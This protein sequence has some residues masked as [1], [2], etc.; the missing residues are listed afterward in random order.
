MEKDRKGRLENGAG[1]GPA[2]TRSIAI[3]KRWRSL[4]FAA[5]CAGGVLLGAA[6]AS[7][8]CTQ[9]TELR[10]L[11]ASVDAHLKCAELGTLGHACHAPRSPP[12]CGTGLP[13]AVVEAV[14]GPT[15]GPGTW[16]SS[17]LGC[18]REIRRAASRYVS[19]RLKERWRLRRP[20]SAGNQFI[21]AAARCQGLVV[22]VDPVAGPMPRLGPVCAFGDPE[23]S[24]RLEQAL[25]C[26]RADLEQAIDTVAPEALR[27]NI[28]IIMT[29]DQRSD[30]LDLMPET[31]TRLAARGT[32]FEN[33]FA[34]SPVCAPSRATLMSGRLPHHQPSG[35]TLGF[36][37]NDTLAVWLAAQGYATGMF[38]KYT[39]ST[40]KIGPVVP[41][42]W[43]SWNVFL[44]GAGGGF[45]GFE[46]SFQGL[47]MPFP[48]SIYSTD[49]LAKQAVSFVRQH[50]QEPFFLMLSAFAPHSPAI[51]A[52]RH[53]GSLAGLEDWRPASWKEADL[54]GKP[55]WVS[56]WRHLIGPAGWVAVDARRRAEFETLLAVDEAVARIDDTLEAAGLTDQT[57]VLYLSDHGI[58]WGEH[59]LP[60]KWS[61]Y[62][63]SIR[64]PLLM[65]WPML[66]PAGGGVRPELVAMPDVT[67]TLAVVAG[68]V[69]HAPDGADLIDFLRQGGP[70][71]EDVLVQSP[72]EF[73]TRPNRAVRT[74][75]WKWI[76]TDATAGVREE[77]YDLVNDPLELTNL[78]SDPA[79]VSER[80]ALRAR[81]AELLGS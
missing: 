38:G 68:A 13:E 70:W 45:Y 30:A 42:G 77:L 27:P 55:D 16:S 11:G 65:R 24:G 4:G 73:I 21:A 53:A 66:D 76:E 34:T 58:H 9:P 1:K 47:F 57:L 75:R 33:S 2:G 37:Q 22:E 74:E 72:G 43:D 28:V 32:R 20:T 49:F 25:R 31:L 6:P 80:E 10:L 26:L 52:E 44:G 51:P 48:A 18:Q 64:I 56:G 39:N 41:P 60:T 67:A 12:A 7:A 40:E 8:R 23:M 59:W 17:A 19:D 50:R 54:S 29:D 5:A 3:R 46:M 81:L 63:E 14:F 69:G 71:R 79:R 61:S 35:T 36:D 15:S 62:E 78:A